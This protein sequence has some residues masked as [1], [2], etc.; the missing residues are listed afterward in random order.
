MKVVKWLILGQRVKRPDG[1]ILGLLG[2]IS[3]LEGLQRKSSEDWLGVG[4]RLRLKQL[5]GAHLRT[6]WELILGLR[7]LIKFLHLD[8]SHAHLSYISF[9]LNKN[10]IQGSKQNICNH[11]RTPFY[12]F[13]LGLGTLHIAVSIHWSIPL[14]VTLVYLSLT[15]MNY[16]RVLRYCSCPTNHCDCFVPYAALCIHFVEK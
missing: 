6:D 9:S 11:W 13:S 8:K 2:W 1:L 12:A 14:S 15:S 16:K 7:G 10:W 4:L 5:E 3:V